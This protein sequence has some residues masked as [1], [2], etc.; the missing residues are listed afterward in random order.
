M[1]D[2]LPYYERELSFLRRHA[3]EFAERYPKI[4]GRLL[5]SGDTCEDPHVER[6]LESFALLAAR[7]QKKLADDF[8]ELTESLLEVLYPH[9]L[10][11]FPSCSIARFD[12]AGAEAQ[13]SGASKIP[14]GTLLTTLAVKGLACKFRTAYDVDIAPVRIVEARY[15]DTISPGR[16]YSAPTTASSMLS[17]TIESRS[18]Q[19]PLDALNLER[20]RIFLDGEPSLVSQIREALL[21]R[22]VAVACEAAPQ[23]GWLPLPDSI[24]QPVG[25]A[26]EEGLLDYDARS[27][28]AYR[29]LTEFF[30]FPEKFNFIDIQYAPLRK[31]LPAGTRRATIRVLLSH[32]RE[33]AEENRLLERASADNFL[34]SC[35]PIVNL[36]KQPGDPIR[37]THTKSSY[38]VVPD[39]R[40]AS[41]Y[42]VYS[43]NRVR[44]VEK[45][46][47]GEEVIEY[48]PF[49]A[50]RHAESLNT[51]G[52]FWHIRRDEEVAQL[53]PGYEYEIAVIDLDFNPLA[54]KTETLSLELT[55]TNRDLPSQLP[56]GMAGGDLSIEGGSVA[57][58]I[59]LLRKPTPSYRFGRANGSHWRLISHLSLNHLSLTEKGL[60]SLKETLALYDITRALT[61][62]R[63]LDG[64]I[65]IQHRPVTATMAGNPFPTFVRGVEIELTVDEQF[66]VGTGIHFF[67]RVLDHFFGLY[68]H[69]NSFTQLVIKS[70]KTGGEI[71]RCPPRSG[72]LPL[73]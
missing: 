40:R 60:E 30:A 69:I 31:Q 15:E 48:R 71:L 58:I 63:Q 17:L 54:E 8:P 52:R 66:Y 44:K 33:S 21:A 19:V 39:A 42:E 10:R 67:A 9:Y 24:I 55:C 6:M 70:A 28:L 59:S 36:F 16:G 3:R 22:R 2:L 7:V 18:D 43:V 41:A 38:P 68:V 51:E 73:V 56:Y 61:N 13:L 64:L 27:H 26:E 35:T 32:A 65:S 25:F 23:P 72:D 4:A 29:L 34:L 46:A 49:Y 47:H 57:K 20:L 45:T 14:R 37:L 50:L 53:S 11:P 62:Q 5:L 12:A 1:N